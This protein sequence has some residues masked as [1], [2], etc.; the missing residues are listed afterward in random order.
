MYE[1][2]Y[3]TLL[4]RRQFFARVARHVLMGLGLVAV[5]LTVG[6]WGYHTFEKM[7]WIDA[8]VNASMI[9]SGM[10]PVTELKTDAGKFFA[11]CYALFS[12]LAFIV[13]IGVIFAPVIHRALHKFHLEDTR[14]DGRSK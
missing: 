8:F 1:N 5:C 12:G 4:P 3:K 14:L 9:L 13:F 10:G 11:G 7:A 6:M 2:R